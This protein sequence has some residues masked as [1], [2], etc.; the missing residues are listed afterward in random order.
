MSK[1]AIKWYRKAAD[2]GDKDAQAELGRCYFYGI[3]VKGDY[4]Q[5]VLW[6]RKDRAKAGNADAQY[7]LGYCYEYGQGVM[8][9]C[10]KTLP[11]CGIKKLPSK[12]T[13]MRAWR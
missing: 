10:G 7:S 12:A 2:Q 4:K 9:N 8:R 5:A 6:Y 13:K 3:G 1:Q 11:F